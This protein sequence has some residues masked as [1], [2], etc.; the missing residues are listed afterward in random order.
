MTCPGWLGPAEGLAS[1][2]QATVEL[3]LGADS[4]AIQEGRVAVLQVRPPGA[5][6]WGRCSGVLAL[7]TQMY[8][9]E[10]QPAR[11]PLCCRA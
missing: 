1:F 11:L 6:C 3:L 9:P 8:A 7:A 2:R 5:C 10:R 4:P